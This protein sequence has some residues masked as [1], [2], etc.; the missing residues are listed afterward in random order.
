MG[1]SALQTVSEENKMMQVQQKQAPKI[2]DFIDNTNS[3]YQNLLGYE[4]EQISLQSIPNSE[5]FDF[6]QQRGLNSNSLGIYLPRNQTAV[7]RE[8]NP[9]SLF[10]EYFG[11]GLYCER[12]LQGRKLVDLEKKLLKEEKQ[13]FDGRRFNLEDLKKFRESNLAFQELDGFRKENL[14][15]Y[16]LFAVWTEYL[17]SKE[18]KLEDFK[19]KYDSLEKE[20]RESVDSVINFNE[21]YGNLATFYASGLAKKTTPERVKKLLKEIYGDKLKN[22][23]FASLYGS[24]KE[25]RDIDVFVVGGDLEEI[26]TNWLDVRVETNVEFENQVRLLDGSLVCPLF[27]AECIIGDKEYFSNMK[28][29]FGKS[30]ITEEAIKH[31][32][33][34]SKE[35]RKMAMGYPK[36]SEGRMQGLAY[37]KSY[38]RNALALKQGKRKLT[39]DEILWGVRG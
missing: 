27:D 19:M 28:N 12:S 7:I 2:S 13:E 8:Q 31:N 16:E 36:D 23:K 11:H 21:Q 37:A 24:R 32:S 17:L 38:L 18:N 15:Q 22:I 10:H 20:D 34:K 26:E 30:P 3:F 14:A 9:L 25:F 29:Q 35:Q 6:T 5:W 39:K 1:W 4:P 33:E